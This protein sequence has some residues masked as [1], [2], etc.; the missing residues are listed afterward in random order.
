VTPS[1]R[2]RSIDVIKE[3]GELAETTFDEPETVENHGL[4]NLGVAEMVKSGGSYRGG[5]QRLLQ[6]GVQT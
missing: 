4:E 2:R 6:R 3:V 1:P 5:L